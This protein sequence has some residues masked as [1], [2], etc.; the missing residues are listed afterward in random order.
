MEKN[1][2]LTGGTG[3]IGSQLAEKFLKKNKNLIFLKRSN[4]N[5]WRI[6]EFINSFDNLTTIDI[7]KVKMNEVFESYNIDGILHLATYYSKFHSSNEI[8]DMVYSN[9]TFPTDLLENAVKN[10]VKYFINTGS[11]AEYSGDKIPINEKSKILPFNLYA[12]TKVGFEDILKFYNREYGIKTA[13]IKLFT[14]YGPKDDENK[15]I[16]Y[17]IINSIKNEKIK[18]Q[19]TS[20][21]LDVLFVDDIINAYEKT[22]KNIKKFKRNENLNIASGNSHSIKEIYSIVNSILGNTDV[23]FLES[24]LSEVKGDFSKAKKLINWKP[25]I[26]LKNGLKLTSDYYKAR[27]ECKK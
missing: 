18:I 12:C 11:Y 4:S 15:I 27:Y 19:S 17:L 2:L 26:D 25:E 9:I 24:D 14:P 20:K 22:I 5:I 10:N 1:I 13:S 21:R 6:E 7:D 3:F 23:E 16:P 8:E